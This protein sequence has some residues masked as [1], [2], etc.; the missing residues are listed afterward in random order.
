M[1][2]MAETSDTGAMWECPLILELQQLPDSFLPAG[3]SFTSPVASEAPAQQTP[4]SAF[5]SSRRLSLER[6]SSELPSTESYTSCSSDGQL[7]DRDG[8][9]TLFVI[10]D[11]EDVSEPP[12]SDSQS[13]SASR[14][15]DSVPLLEG[16]TTRETNGALD[17]LSTPAEFS[18]ANGA[19]GR[20]SGLLSAGLASL[21]IDEPR[22]VY[23]HLM[24]VSP[25]APTNPVL[26]WLGGYDTQR[27][28]FLLNG[29]KGPLR[30]DLGDILYAPNL[31]VD[32][33]VNLEPTPNPCLHPWFKS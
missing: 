20:P 32:A 4:G 19:P 27:T 18:A 23:T 10:E 31:L 14:G 9:S 21:K 7:M 29:A 17:D 33:Q 26:Y 5:L 16:F 28:E 22:P 13:V 11:D 6:R 1:L 15:Q 12:T 3:L 30:L 25:D 8:D 2:C 24:C